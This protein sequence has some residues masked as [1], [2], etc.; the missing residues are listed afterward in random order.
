MSIGSKTAKYA[1]AA[2]LISVLVVAASLLYVGVQPPLQRQRSTPGLQGQSVLAIRLTDPP[3]VPDLTSSLNLTYSSLSVL[4]GVPSGHD[5]QFN[6]SSVT[7]TPSGGSATLDLLKLQNVSQTI[8]KASLPNDSVVYSIT[9]TVT[10]ISIDV[11]GTIFPV[12]PASGGNTLTVTM[13]HPTSLS[14]NDIAL[15]QL[16]PVVVKTPNGYQLI[17]SAVGIIRAHSEND[18]GEEQ[19]GSEHELTSNET[20]ALDDARGNVTA[21]FVALSVSG[22]STTATF[23]IRNTGNI[24]IVLNAIGVHGNFTALGSACPGNEVT[25]NT[26]T[27]ESH[28]TNGQNESEATTETHTESTNQTVASPGDQECE[29]FEHADEVVFVPVVQSIALAN[30]SS[31]ASGQLALVNEDTND[32][33]DMGL[34]LKPGQCV[35]LTFTGPISF[36]DSQLILIPSTS[37]GQTYSVHIIASDGANVELGCVLPLGPDSCKVQQP[38]NDT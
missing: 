23:E 21:S 36:G 7:V 20:D 27:T 3:L 1:A 22:N 11:N 12:A 5:D 33:E 9:L 38:E 30:S 10:S 4:V 31:C 26:T 29:D 17:P 13:A 32:S 14:G 37:P 28:T 34:T 2:A 35:D 8:A 6:V 25:N 16:N 15:L 18:Q 19:V 24:S